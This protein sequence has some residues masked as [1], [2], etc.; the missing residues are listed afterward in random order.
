MDNQ[1]SKNTIQQ[2]DYVKLLAILYSRWYWIVGCVM[3]ALV[4]GYLY[5]WY[6]PPV[7]ITTASLKFDEKRSEF[8]ELLNSSSP[9]YER[10]NKIQ[11]ASFVI[12][13]RNIILAAVS[14][15]DYKIS[16]Y[17]EGRLRTS[18]LYPQVPFP[19]DIVYQD[20][21]N[22]NTGIFRIKRLNNKDFELHYKKNNRYIEEIYSF[23]K[24][25]EADNVHFIVKSSFAPIGAEYS[26]KFN[27]EQDFLGRIS[28]GLNMREAS[29]G[30]NIM[31]LTLTDLN[32]RFA[33]DILNAIIQEYLDSDQ[34]EKSLSA[35]QMITFIESQ[36]NFLTQQVKRSGSALAEFKQGNNLVDLPTSTQIYVGQLTEQQSQ[37]N[38]LN[39]Q[40]LAIDQLEQ[41]IQNNNDNVGINFNLEG[42]PDPLLAG[43]IDQL[44]KQILERDKRL[45][46]FN[47]NSQ[48]VEDIIKQIDGTKRAIINNI[49][50]LRIRNQKTIKYIED[51]IRLT[52]QSLNVLPSAEKDFVNLQADFNINQK[53]FSYLSE[54][55]LEAQISR[56]AVIP[57]ASIVNKALPAYQ[58]VA[59]IPP[60][61]YTTC[62]F[63]GL[64]GGIGLIVLVRVLNPYIYDKETIENLT[65]IPIIGVIRKFPGYMDQDN[66]QALS[67][68]KPKTVFAESIR[69]V[70]T[71]LSFLASEKQSK[72]ICITSEISG[73]GKSFVSVNLAST[74]ALIDKKVI[75]IG[76]DLRRS[77]LHKTFG[78]DNKKGLSTYLSN[79]SILE[80]IIYKTDMEFL[81][82]IP[83]GPVPPNPSELLHNER[84][85]QLL[86]ILRKDYDYILLDTAPVGLVSDSIPLIRQTDIN[87]FIIRSGVSKHSAASIPNRLALE[88]G[89]Q[90][91]VIV[92]NAFSGDP[93]Y[94]RYYSTNYSRSSGYGHYYYSDY[95][96]Y[97]DSGYYTSDTEKKWWQKIFSRI[98]N[99]WNN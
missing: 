37:K 47:D 16:Y 79:Q 72:V 63:L 14:R 91:I 9:S 83:S 71:N 95:T 48:P 59:P 40:Q 75:L 32:P 68:Q 25:I 46:L 15:L 60:S 7:Y 73:E 27:S 41:Q 8:S 77:K 19:I 10:G 80:E 44:N 90:N 17:L 6:T 54:K 78:N 94:N 53:V 52:Q 31:L 42:S 93:L 33:A 58:I 69:S 38:I 21:L 45:T 29:K 51:Q 99:G 24:L 70:R 97:Y 82:F 20:S 39:I 34:S 76:A 64:A 67:L 22:V 92:L 18:D 55:R 30:S 26:F 88:Y 61:I 87:L 96:G 74:L 50:L 56:A 4:I 3:L 43:L 49:K 11:S 23:G 5:L 89:L 86:E 1:E 35:S 13:S 85:V 28:T 65:N 62:I 98:R 36:L 57:G 81:D 2:V 66:K 84:M 12:E